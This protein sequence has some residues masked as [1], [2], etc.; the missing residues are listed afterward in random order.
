MASPCVVHLRQ[1]ER[2]LTDLAPIFISLVPAHWGYATPR[3]FP[4]SPKF[5]TSTEPGEQDD[6]L[7]M[8]VDMASKQA[9][10]LNCRKSKI[11][12]KRDVGASV[13][14][15]C[16][17]SGTECIIPSFHIGRQKG[18]KNKRT[19]LE[20]AIFQIEEAIK[21]SK[22]DTV[23][24]TT[25]AQLQQLLH[26]ARGGS[27]SADNDTSP[28]TNDTSFVPERDATLSSDDQLALD[29]A[30]NPLQLLARAS[31]LRLATPQSTDPNGGTPASR[32]QFSN[33]REE[34]SDVHRFFLPMQAKPDLGPDLDPID[35][36]LLTTEEAEMLLSYYHEKLAHTRWG[37]DPRTHTMPFVRS[38][39]AFLLTSLLLA[40]ALFLPT[41]A[42]L[43]KRLLLHRN[44]LAQQVVARRFR[45]VEIVLAFMVNVPWMHPGAHAADD[46]TGLYISMAL[47]IALDL[48]LNKIITPSAS[49]D[50]EL[51]KRVPKADC[52]DAK[53]AL[54][55]DGYEDVDPL[56]DWGQTLL[57]R[58]ERAWIALFV[59]DR[60][61]CLARG[62]NFCA[63]VTPLLKYCE[64]W[65]I[66]GVSDLQDGAMVS[67]AALRRD[68]DDLFSTVRARCDSYRVIDVGS[69]VAKEIETMIDTFFN[70]W[71][72]TWTAAIG[73]GESRTLP[74]YVEIMQSHTR[75][76][77]YSSVINHPTAP[78][79]VKRLFRASE[80][81]S[82]LNV[83]RAAIQGESRLKSM[84]NNTVIMICFAACIALNMTPGGSHNLAPSVRNLIEEAAA[85]L[86]RI[87]STPAH[88]N[89]ASLLYGKYLRE[90]VRHAPVL[91]TALAQPTSGNIIAPSSQL[92]VQTYTPNTNSLQGF[93]QAQSQ[94][95]LP[96]SWPELHFSAMSGNEVVETVMNAGDFD[97]TLWDVPL[98]DASNS[99]TWM[100]WMNPPDFGFQ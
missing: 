35:M 41:T 52:I 13:C 97:S 55:M 36:G 79:E 53:R 29:D 19:G 91:S 78:L 59:L 65:P 67:I 94:Y 56:S 40:S 90:L 63:P 47:S 30:E 72:E 71:L 48:S 17:Q 98:A 81:S 58:R 88:R 86:E 37:T 43:A 100:D 32:N 8:P 39:S 68:L 46:D 15:K 60:G 84:P 62:R 89:G 23:Q 49:F 75:L 38:R 33:D 26:D 12:C 66:E 64:K 77:T 14:E 45:S 95:T 50:Q 1:L 87:G 51:L 34:K 82:A 61:I 6:E 4:T 42:A 44:F 99:F 3:C 96:N 9:A 11:R 5:A 22:P 92:D 83:L 16:Q 57:R 25:L 80:L 28:S 76:S 7:E 10:C 21:K 85:V 20:K 2:R 24:D 54:A 18:V 27:A 73:E 31:D 70:S 93:N 74:P 69:K